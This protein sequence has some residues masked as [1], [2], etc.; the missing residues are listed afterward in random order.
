MGSIEETLQ[1]IDRD[2]INIWKH[3]IDDIFVIWT[4]SN[5]KYTTKHMLDKLAKWSEPVWANI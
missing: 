3:F 2:H 5:V 1:N 4:E